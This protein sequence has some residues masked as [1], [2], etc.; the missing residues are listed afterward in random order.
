[1]A[2]ALLW[3]GEKKDGA[4]MENYVFLPERG[5]YKNKKTGCIFCSNCLV[6]GLES[7][8]AKS[9]TGPRLYWQCANKECGRTIDRRA[10]DDEGVVS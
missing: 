3:Q 4:I 5:F 9:M 8:M 1:M 10:S 7:S 6:N 2:I